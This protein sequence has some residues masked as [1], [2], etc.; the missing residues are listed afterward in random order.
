M[1][2]FSWQ[3]RTLHYLE[4]GEPGRPLL[5]ILPGS[6]ASAAS[7]LGD[8]KHFGSTHHV[9]AL[10]YLGTGR[11][12][13]LERWPLDWWESAAAQ[14]ATLAAH[15]DAERYTLLGCSGGGT[16]ALLAAAIR[17]DE[18]GAVIADSCPERL[19]P[20]DLRRIAGERLPSAV[21]DDGPR[22]ERMPAGAGIVEQPLPGSL[23]EWVWRE[24]PRRLR[25]LIAPPQCAFWRQ[26]HGDD[27]EDVVAA[28]TALLLEL[29]EHGGWQPLA[30]RLGD[31]RCPVL[32]TSSLNDEELPSVVPQH[33]RMAL[34]I[35]DCRLWVTPRGGHPAMWTDK[36][37]FRRRAGRFL[38]EA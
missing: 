18:V 22:D 20:A 10:D 36:R 23:V 35:A 2:F 12:D 1:P 15:L 8:L 21:T 24:G 37:G 16:L 6:T 4:A 32:L 11:S 5:L 29:A 7:H 17:P 30:G 13:R 28:D 31:I 27:W 19:E 33:Q 9:A 3:R 38:G 14:V 34:G 26:A 25:E